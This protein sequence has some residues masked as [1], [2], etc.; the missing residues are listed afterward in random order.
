MVIN[1]ECLLVICHS[2]IWVSSVVV[3][4]AKSDQGLKLLIIELECL[5]MVLDGLFSV[6]SLEE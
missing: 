6:S 3:G 4:I 2:I 1:I 5:E